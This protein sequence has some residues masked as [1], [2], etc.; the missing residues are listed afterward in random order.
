M[1]YDVATSPPVLAMLDGVARVFMWTA[2][3]RQLTLRYLRPGDV[4]GLGAALGDGIEVSTE[5]VTD[6]TAAVVSVEHLRELS[7]GHPELSWAIA[8]QVAGWACDV[9]LAVA[10]LEHRPMTARVAAHLL[11]LATPA[12]D[13]EF[14]VHVSHQGL[15][16]AA[17]SVREVVTR[18]LRQL[19]ET[20]VVDTR[21]GTV[22]IVDSI[23]LA[24]I[25][26]GDDPP[27]HD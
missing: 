9:V 19:R 5:A 16:D 23:R 17:G 11:E 21:H 3:G 7:A 8:R 27:V 24:R 15:A 26:R 20:G 22:I 12:S 2:G 13:G 6:T 1:L 14:V 10:D 4:V 25:A 18:A